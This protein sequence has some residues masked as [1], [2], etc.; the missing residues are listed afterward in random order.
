MALL[1]ERIMAEKVEMILTSIVRDRPMGSDEWVRKIAA[2][3]GLA[4][5]LR[6][7]GRPR[8]SREAK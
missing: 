1:N 6:P 7:R 2:K 5:T 8:K 4:Y 3:M